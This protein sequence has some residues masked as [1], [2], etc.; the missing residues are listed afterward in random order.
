VSLEE[1]VTVSDCFNSVARI[2]PVK[3]E[4]P[5]ACLT[6]NCKLCK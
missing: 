6:M 3:T 4:N 2:R 1:L 5:S